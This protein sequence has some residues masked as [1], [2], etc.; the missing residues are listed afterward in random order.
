MTFATPPFPNGFCEGKEAADRRYVN[1][2]PF[3]HPSFYEG[4]F[5]DNMNIWSVSNF[6]LFCRTLREAWI[7]I[8]MGRALCDD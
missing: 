1:A 5:Y 3:Q 4:Y 8:R 2:A 6:Y 7:E